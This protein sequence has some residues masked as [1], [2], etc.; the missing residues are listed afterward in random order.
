LEEL[1]SEEFHNLYSLLS[2]FGMMNW[3]RMRSKGGEEECMWE[4]Q[5][6]RD[7][8]EDHDVGGWVILRWILG[9]TEW[10]GINWISVG[11]DRRR[12]GAVV[13]TV[14]NIYFIKCWDTVE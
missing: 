10:S 3:R 7:H 13:N 4:C 12:W 5:E 6:K 1:H 8:Q 11:R 9:E 2:I 14:M